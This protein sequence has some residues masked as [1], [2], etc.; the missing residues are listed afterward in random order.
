MQKTGL[1]SRSPVVYGP[2]MRMWRN[3]ANDGQ[4]CR[5]D[6]AGALVLAGA[7]RVPRAGTTAGTC[8]HDPYT[9]SMVTA[10]TPCLIRNVIRGAS[11][12]AA[13]VV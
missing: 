6:R 2:H 10:P 1:P 12:R 4:S 9:A 7:C 3:P 8:C 11:G 5:G 13:A